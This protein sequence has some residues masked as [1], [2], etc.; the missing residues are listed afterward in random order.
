M[1][2]FTMIPLSRVERALSSARRTG[3]CQALIAELE[4]LRLQAYS[5]EFF[6]RE[7]ELALERAEVGT[8]SPRYV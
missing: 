7:A 4:L 8:R 6:P 3:A 2:K 5:T 1:E